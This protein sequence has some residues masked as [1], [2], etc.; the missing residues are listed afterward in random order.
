MY[1]IILLIFV[2]GFAWSLCKVASNAD[3]NLKR[4]PPCADCQYS[5]DCVDYCYMMEQWMTGI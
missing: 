1:W 3:R 4:D 2:I 5:N